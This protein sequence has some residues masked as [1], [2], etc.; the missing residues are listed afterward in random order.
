MG[1]PLKFCNFL[2]GILPEP[3]A[4][5]RIYFYDL[6][7]PKPFPSPSG[8]GVALC[9][10]PLSGWFDSLYSFDLIS[11]LKLLLRLLVGPWGNSAIAQNIISFLTIICAWTKMI[12][13]C[14]SPDFHL[15]AH[16]LRNIHWNC[17]IRSASDAHLLNWTFCV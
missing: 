7:H 17:G 12:K 9:N 11:T 2:W 1:I 4:G 14:K 10:W 15:F 8:S 3:L 13:I 6:E 5:G 16:I